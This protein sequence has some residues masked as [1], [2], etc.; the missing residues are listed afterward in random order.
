MKQSSPGAA[1][2]DSFITVVLFWCSLIVV[3]SVYIT[4]PLLSLFAERFEVSSSTAAWAG[5][6]FSF[7]FAGGGLVFGVLS[8]R[9]GRK[10][11]MVT[12]LLL[13][14]VTT[15]CIGMVTEFAWLIA[16]RAV[17][18]LA[19]SMFPPSVLAYAMEM[20]PAKK[21]VT[22]IG[23]I[24]TAFLMASIIGQIYSSYVVLHWD[25]SYVFYILCAVYFVSFI[26]LGTTIPSDPRAQATGSFF[27]PFARVGLIFKRK[28]LPICYI[29]SATL[30]TALVGY[31]STLGSYLTS[32]SFGLTHQDILWI[33]AVGIIGMFISP[34]DGRLVARYGMKKVLW[35]GLVLGALGL[36]TLSLG[37]NLTF[38]TVMSVVFAMGVAMALPALISLI[39]HLAGEIRAIAV[40]FHMFMLFIGASLGPIVSVYLI[41]LGGHTFT[42]GVLAGLL[43]ASTI[44]PV[45]IRLEATPVNAVVSS[46]Q[47]SSSYPKQTM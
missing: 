2:N 29:I 40:S 37:E 23:F 15:L 30:F 42:F 10:R 47:A 5:S 9:Y 19:A 24:S 33:R 18:G 46:S 7:A 8:D 25:W 1:R 20:F 13:L 12:G 4:I 28:G 16:L 11:L 22:I 26:V 38:L 43:L 27:A 6:A 41:D 31:F 21:R 45:F 3:S 44:V 14:T 34:F 32:D 36:G 35:C 17:Q 39:G